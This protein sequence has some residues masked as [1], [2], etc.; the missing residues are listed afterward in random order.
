MQIYYPYG[1]PKEGEDVLYRLEAQRY[2]YVIDAD[3]EEY[4]TTAPR[5][6]MHFYFV[7]KRTPKGAWI[8]NQFVLLSASKRFA[9]NTVEEAIESFIARKRK[10]IKILEAQL[11]RAQTEL[12]LT[13][14]SP[15]QEL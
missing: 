13:I 7:T 9:C 14:I 12:N 5:L 3:R 6:E 4:G 10:Q 15:I 2:S 8:G 1:K 11:S